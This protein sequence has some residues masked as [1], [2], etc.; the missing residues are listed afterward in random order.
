M[1]GKEERFAS[2]SINVRSFGMQRESHS[3]E[4]MVSKIALYS[5]IISARMYFHGSIRLIRD[6]HVESFR[7]GNVGNIPSIFFVSLFFDRRYRESKIG[8]LQV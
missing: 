1:I 7:D 5:R 4:M 3:K 2:E 6:K 8:L